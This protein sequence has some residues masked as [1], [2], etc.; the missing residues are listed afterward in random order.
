M[1]NELKAT[2]LLFDQYFDG[3]K[4]DQ[5]RLREVWDAKRKE[6]GI[7]QADVKSTL[8]ISSESAISH[9]LNGKIPLNLETILAFALILK[10]PVSDISPSSSKLLKAVQL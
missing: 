9:Y 1:N 5:P 8:S 3:G 10:V 6:L 2:K 4:K 7:T